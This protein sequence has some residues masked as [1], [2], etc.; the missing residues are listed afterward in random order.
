MV[1]LG[2]LAAVVVPRIMDRPGEAKRTKAGVD[3]RAIGQALELYRLDNHRYPTTQQGLE[4]LVTKP[5]AEPI[6]NKWKKGGYL[7]KLPKDPWG[8][9]YVYLFPGLEGDYDIISYGADLS[10]GGEE[11]A[12]D[13]ASWEIDGT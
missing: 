2:L 12:A 4:A 1:I 13:I 5:D 9:P 8:N 3:I 10:P 7:G 6:P 11:E